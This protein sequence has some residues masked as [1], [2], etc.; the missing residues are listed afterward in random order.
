[1]A[2]YDI[3]VGDFSK[4]PLTEQKKVLK[5]AGKLVDV[6]MANNAKKGVTTPA[7]AS[8]KGK[9]GSSY[10]HEKVKAP[11][12]VESS[13]YF[14]ELMS[15]INEG[16]RKRKLVQR[17]K[18]AYKK[19]KK[20]RKE[21]IKRIKEEQ[22][23]FR[24]QQRELKK[25]TKLNLRYHKKTKF[26]K[27]KAQAEGKTSV[28]KVVGKKR[29]EAYKKEKLRE[30]KKLRGRQAKLQAAGININL[31]Q[32]KDMGDVFKILR[33]EHILNIYVDSTTVYDLLKNAVDKSLDVKESIEKLLK[34]KDGNAKQM[35]IDLFKSEEIVNFAQFSDEEDAKEQV[36]ALLNK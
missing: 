21:Q 3:S 7:Q 8:L 35:V 26:E 24:E 14:S 12:G 33:E 11:Q 30:L 32:A 19:E 31:A 29:F 9:Y 27:L 4:L 20:R 17:E 15:V 22:R 1:M 2:I 25:Q 5:A 16:T 6:V 13:K 28:S 23:K 36:M 10:K 34:T 18:Q